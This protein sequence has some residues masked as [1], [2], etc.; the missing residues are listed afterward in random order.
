MAQAVRKGVVFQ[1][2]PPPH[3]CQSLRLGPLDWPALVQLQLAQTKHGPTSS[4]F[5][6]KQIEITLKLSRLLAEPIKV[7]KQP[8]WFMVEP[9]ENLA[10]FQLELEDVGP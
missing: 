6:P 8:S 9:R 5:N 1:G 7:F 3:F 4:C 10:I 2:T